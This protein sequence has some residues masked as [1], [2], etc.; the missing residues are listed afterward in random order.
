MLSMREPARRLL[1]PGRQSMLGNDALRT[2]QPLSKM[3]PM[4][5]SNGLVGEGV[6]IKT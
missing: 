6:R 5:L 3:N 2:S 4:L 1:H